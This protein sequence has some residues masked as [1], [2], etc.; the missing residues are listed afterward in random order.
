M[1]KIGL[2][3]G[4]T[5]QSTTEYYKYINELV[6]KKLG[7]L[8]SAKILLA[9]VDYEDL[10]SR[11]SDD[12]WSD[13]INRLQ[14]EAQILKNGGADFFLICA[15]TLH[16]IAPQVLEKVG[17]PFVCIIEETAKQIHKKGLKKVALLGTKYTTLDSFYKE[18]LAKHGI[19]ALIP[20]ER[21]ALEINRVIYEELA[22]ANYKKSSRKFYCNC[23]ESL[24]KKGAEG[25]I[26]GCTEIPLLIQQEHVDVPTFNT[27][28]IHCEAAVSEALS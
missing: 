16:K 20:D 21:D 12:D 11:F 10:A 7:G 25:V 8:H 24:V 26:L 14:T 4:V 19:E 23:I 2:I 13:V 18:G 6:A 15:N 1:K 27:T 22:F 9:S 17:L 3:G 5:W 28:L